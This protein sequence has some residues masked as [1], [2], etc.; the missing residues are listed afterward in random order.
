MKNRHINNTF[1]IMKKTYL[2][3]VLS[4]FG[5]V[6]FAQNVGVGTLTPQTNLHVNSTGS[7]IIRNETNGGFE[8]ALELKTAGS[9]FDF[10]ELRKWRTGAGGSTGGIPLNGLSQI[11]TGSFTTG[12]LLLGTKP[13]QPLYFTTDNTERMRIAADGNVGINT[14]NP[15]HALHVTAKGKYGIYSTA[16][17]NGSDTIAGVYGLA[18][19]PTPVPYSAGVRGESNSTNF[20]GI[21]VL[22]IQRGSGW[23]VAGFA[24]EGGLGYGAGVLGSVGFNLTGNGNGGY[25]VYGTN[26]NIGGS[27]GFFEDN[28]GSTTS[29]ALKTT[30]KLKFNGIGEA[31]GK[32]LTSDASG[33]ATWGNLPTTTGTWSVSGNNIYNSNT[34]YVGIGH[35]NPTYALD[36]RNNLNGSLFLENPIIAPNATVRILRGVSEIGSYETTALSVAACCD[37]AAIFIGGNGGIS[38]TSLSVTEAAAKLV[39]G[40]TGTGIALELNGGIRVDNA[41]ANKPVFIHVA[42]A[43]NI[44]SNTT[45]ITYLNPS[46]TDFVMVTPNW[47]AGPVYNNHPIGVYFVGGKWAIF[48]QDFAA[49]PVGTAFNVMVIRQ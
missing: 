16:S 25:G 40:G 6:I 18:L 12:G 27:G 17:A 23:G 10:L 44:S 11:T 22:G 9:V 3:I 38:A 8:A 39:G 47:T 5:R 48:N 33:N 28:N 43:A 24:K 34:G 19:S 46:A 13:A 35:N 42:T 30:G 1:L 4:L 49:M 21:G 32:V 7:T 36:V 31:A 26:D 14:I 15:A 45:S 20:N 2:L 41:A 37:K 29:Y